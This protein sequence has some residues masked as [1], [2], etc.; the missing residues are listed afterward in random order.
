MRRMPFVES[1]MDLDELPTIEAATD[2]QVFSVPP[3]PLTLNI[4][5]DPNFNALLLGPQLLLPPN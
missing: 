3:R 5:K 4:E 2:L 1:S